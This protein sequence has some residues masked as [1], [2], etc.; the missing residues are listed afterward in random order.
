[1]TKAI[2][3]RDSFFD[4]YKALLILCVV[5]GHF[6]DH[7]TSDFRIAEILRIYIY[8]FHIPAFSF[9]SGYFARKNNFQILVQKLLVPYIVFQVIYY[10]MYTGIGRDV[11]FTLLSPFFTLW[12]LIALFFWRLI[13]NPASRIK[14]LLFVSFACSILIGFIPDC[15]DFL[16]LSR[17]VAFFPFFVMGHQFNKQ[18]FEKYTNKHSIKAASAILLVGLFIFIYYHYELFEI[19]VLNCQD[20][21]SELG[22]TYTGWFLRFFFLV[23]AACLIYAIAAI[24]PKKRTPYTFLGK[25]TMR[26]YLCHGLIYKYLSLG[27]DVLDIVNGPTDFLIYLVSVILMAFALSY[28]PLESFLEAITNIPK[29]LLIQM[30]QRYNF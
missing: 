7:F 23:F 6:L 29:Q 25:Y 12:Y 14:H 8:F 18:T 21:Y 27:T 13:I 28:I 3:T 17:V 11:E 22:Q 26:V 15:A 16:S 30:K 20:C 1:M 4:N 19:P 2:K 10:I 24:I 9:I 5:I